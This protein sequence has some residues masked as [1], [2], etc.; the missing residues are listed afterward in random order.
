MSSYKQHGCRLV[1]L[2][3][4]KLLH[5]RFPETVSTKY[6]PISDSLKAGVFKTLRSQTFELSLYVQSGCMTSLE[7]YITRHIFIA[8]LNLRL[9]TRNRRYWRGEQYSR[10]LHSDILKCT[11][12]PSIVQLYS[13]SSVPCLVISCQLSCKLTYSICFMNISA[14]SRLVVQ[15]EPAYSNLD[16]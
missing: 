3:D 8:P 12:I 7:S 10:R 16:I 1:S 11:Q 13:F 6:L 4:K 2:N 15:R 14:Q 9:P 5:E